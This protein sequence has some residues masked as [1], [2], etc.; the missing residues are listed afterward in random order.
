MVLSLL[1]LTLL[2]DAVDVSVTT[3]PE[4]KKGGPQVHVNILE[5]IAGF[6]LKLKR[7]DG[8]E[9]D[10]KGGGKPGVTR[11][12]ELAQPEG[13]FTWVGELGVNFP[14]GTTQVMP[15]TFDTEIYGQLRMT[16][17]KEDV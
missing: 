8:K 1:A 2:T 3:R 15:L 17:K 13:K 14:N 5:P 9:L 6:R 16:L 11:D 10:V 7:S 4:L 12:I